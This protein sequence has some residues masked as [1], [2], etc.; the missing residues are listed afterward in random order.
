MIQL[1]VTLSKGLFLL[2]GVSW[3]IIFF[4]GWTYGRCLRWAEEGTD[5]PDEFE[6]D[7]HSG[8]DIG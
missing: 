7:E 6:D 3:A 1:T 4:I 8:T 5:K 2:I